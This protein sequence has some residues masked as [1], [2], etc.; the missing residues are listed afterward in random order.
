[1]PPAKQWALD[2]GDWLGHFMKGMG[3]LW[4]QRA[5]DLGTEENRRAVKLNPQCAW[6]A[7]WPGIAC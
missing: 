2:D 4:T 7:P 6:R 5:H 1:M 3:Y